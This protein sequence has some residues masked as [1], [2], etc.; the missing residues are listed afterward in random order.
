[1]SVFGFRLWRWGGIM[2]VGVVN[3]DPLCKWQVQVYVYCA[4]RIPAHL[5]CT[6]S[7]IQ[8]H[9]IDICFLPCICLWQISQ[10]QT[11]LCV[12][13]MAFTEN[14]KILP[15][16]VGGHMLSTKLFCFNM[17]SVLIHFRL[18]AL[19]CC[20]LIKNIIV[21]YKYILQFSLQNYIL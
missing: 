4:R 6:Q 18:I 8:L 12:V 1:M 13:V 21:L 19:R 3:L 15:V 7:S 9:I 14:E 17:I 11:C 5:M 2:S 20:F 10:I 16:F